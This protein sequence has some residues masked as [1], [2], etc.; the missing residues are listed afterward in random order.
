M[1]NIKD[2]RDTHEYML[3]DV[4]TDGY[5]EF[6]DVLCRRVTWGDSLKVEPIDDDTYVIINVYNGQL[7][8]LNRNAWVKPISDR[9]ITLYVED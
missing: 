2:N 6:D 5:F 8:A 3:K 7:M 1:L 4:E 9:Q